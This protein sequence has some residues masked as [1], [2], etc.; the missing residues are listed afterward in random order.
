MS[1]SL[2]TVGIACH[3]RK[4]S[5]QNEKRGEK[6][7]SCYTHRSLTESPTK[8]HTISKHHRRQFDVPALDEIFNEIA[9][10]AGRAVRAR[11][12]NSP[13]ISLVHTVRYFATS[14]LIQYLI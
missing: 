7:V 11:E 6:N 13:N 3:H 1:F 2:S 14:I 10:L 9:T 12:R 5:F 8:P 4:V